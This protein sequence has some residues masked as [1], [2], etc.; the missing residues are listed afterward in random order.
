MEYGITNKSNT[1]VNHTSNAISEL[2]QQFLGDIVQTFKM[3]GT[4][5]D[6]YSPRSG[7]FSAAAFAFISTK[8]R[9]KVYSTSQLLFGHDTILPIKN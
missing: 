3:G 8:N 1:S 7:I 4:Y 2:I 5:D 9:L 6:K